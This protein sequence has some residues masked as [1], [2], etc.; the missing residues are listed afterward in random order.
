MVHNSTCVEW[1]TLNLSMPLRSDRPR[2]DVTRM[3]HNERTDA[4][5]PVLDLAMS[6]QI[7][8]GGLKFAWVGRI[9]QARHGRAPDCLVLLGL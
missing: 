9:E 4:A 7:L 2:I 5:R 1:L 3:R 8:H 6:Q